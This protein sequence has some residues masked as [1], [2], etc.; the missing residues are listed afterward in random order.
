MELNHDYIEKGYI[1]ARSRTRSKSIGLS[2]IQTA[3]KNLSAE[4]PRFQTNN[5]GSL[6]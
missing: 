1:F 6:V 2:I 4:I 3:E 5:L